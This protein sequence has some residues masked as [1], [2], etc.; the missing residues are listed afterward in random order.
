M[1][2]SGWKQYST[3]Q[4]LSAF[5]MMAGNL[6]LWVL[7]PLGAPDADP[8]LLAVKYNMLGLPGTQVPAPQ[9]VGMLGLVRAQ[10]GL[11]QHF[12]ELAISRDLSTVQL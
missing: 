6:E 9:E 3:S 1:T 10:N 8:N 7:T 11:Y 12:R 2:P 4:R 5:L